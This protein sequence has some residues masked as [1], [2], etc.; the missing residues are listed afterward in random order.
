MNS[1]FAPK[2]K[3][4]L[5]QEYEK[6]HTLYKRLIDEVCFILGDEIAKCGI[7]IHGDVKGRIKTYDSLHNKMLRKEVSDY[8]A[9]ISDIAGVR[10]ICLYRSDLERLGRLIS[11]SFDVLSTDTSRNRTETQ[12]GYM[13]DHYIVRL[14]QES[15][16]KRYDEI[17]ALKCEVQVRTIL[18]DAWASVSHHL[19]YKK[20]ID[21]PSKSRKDFNAVS[22]L[23]YAA[24]THFELF[25]DA[26]D[27]S[28]KELT[29]GMESDKINLEQEVNLDSLQAYLEWRMPDRE[30][31]SAEFYSVLVSDLRSFG[32]RRI[33]EV[34][35]VIRKSMEAAEALEIEEMET[36]FYTDTGL[37]KICLLISDGSYRTAVKKNFA[38]RN[39]KLFALIDKYNSKVK[40]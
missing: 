36:R 30:R 40:S 29:E 13:A 1:A 8:P 26:V 23:L 11:E 14:M 27:Q 35:E 37:L 18:M 19:A 5:K 34:D 16:G 22:G 6:S 2:S 15:R 17:K 38:N 12:F 20:E 25:K 3:K 33:L 31:T 28:R 24:D 32:Y 7:K 10:I 4:R 39:E 21:I 9:E